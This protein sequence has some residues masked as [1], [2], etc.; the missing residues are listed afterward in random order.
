MYSGITLNQLE[1]Y[2]DECMGIIMSFADDDCLVVVNNI[3]ERC[4]EE[5]KEKLLTLK[6]NK[7]EQV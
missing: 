3:I 5:L 4:A 1:N 7:D 2:F 6:N